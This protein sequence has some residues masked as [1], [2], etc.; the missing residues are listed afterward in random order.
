[1]TIEKNEAD[2]ALLDLISKIGVLEWRRYKKHY[3]TVWINGH[4]EVGNKPSSYPSTSFRFQDENPEIINILNKALRSYKGKVEWVMISQEKEY[5]NGI[6]RCILP[7]YIKDLQ[8]EVD[9]VNSVEEYISANKPDFSSKAFAD[10]I[11]LTEHI[12]TVLNTSGIQV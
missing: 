4:L 2:R 10:L 3:P 1:M 6:N 9:D 5:G 11:N 12:R 7:K 8:N